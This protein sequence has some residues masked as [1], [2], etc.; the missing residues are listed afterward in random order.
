LRWPESGIESRGLRG[1]EV[2][3]EVSDLPP[4]EDDEFSETGCVALVAH[5]NVRAE[6][7]PT[8][9]GE[10]ANE[11]NIVGRGRDVEVGVLVK[12]KRRDSG[13]G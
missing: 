4:P 5:R 13:R 6:G 2:G 7:P 8:E 10:S 11:E 1:N 12:T 9:R 3:L